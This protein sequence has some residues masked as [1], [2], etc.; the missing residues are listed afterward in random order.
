MVISVLFDLKRGVSRRFAS[1]RGKMLGS[2]RSLTWLLL[3][4]ELPTRID[5]SLVPSSTAVPT[6]ASIV[7]FASEP[8]RRHR[9][10][11]RR[12]SRRR[13]RRRILFRLPL[14]LRL[15]LRL[16]TRQ[17]RLRPSFLTHERGLDR[18]VSIGA[19]SSSQF[20]E[21][22]WRLTSACV[23]RHRPSSGRRARASALRV[24]QACARRSRAQRTRAE[25]WGVTYARRVGSGRSAEAAERAGGILA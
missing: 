7:S 22:G 16:A 9:F 5:P 1:A 25:E 15:H 24:R 23:V 3:L 10:R 14:P 4:G 2:R 17:R 12:L 18:G 11:R 21:R 13:P 6:S 19:S 8:T 20:L